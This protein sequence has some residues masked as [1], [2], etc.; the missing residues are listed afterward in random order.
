[1][2]SSIAIAWDVG[3]A[4]FRWNASQHSACTA[5]AAA[6][7]LTEAPVLHLL[8]VN[9]SLYFPRPEE[10]QTVDVLVSKYCREPDLQKRDKRREGKTKGEKGTSAQLSPKTVKV[11]SHT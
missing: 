8:R 6:D 3:W 1:M 4:N 2:L 10:G 7:Q 11:T 5:P 9:L